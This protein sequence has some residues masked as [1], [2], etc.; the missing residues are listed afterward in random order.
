MGVGADVAALVEIDAEVLQHALVHGMHEAHGEQ[1]ELR[2]EF[3]FGSRDRLELV[4][5][6]DA[7]QLLHLAVLAG[8][9]LGQHREFALGAFGLARRGPHLQR[10]VRRGAALALVLSP[11]ARIPAP[12]PSGSEETR[13]FC[14][15]RKSIAKWMP[16]RSRPGIGRSRPASAPPVSAT[17]SYWFSSSSGATAPREVRPPR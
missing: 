2:V 1:H 9:F 5:D 3:E 17:A 8:E 15:G 11:R 10:P 7:V 13:R 14:C 4:V 12:A 6:L 16:S